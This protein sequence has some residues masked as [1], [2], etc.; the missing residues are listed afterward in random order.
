MKRLLSL[1]FSAALSSFGSAQASDCD[2]V[3][4][5]QIS[6]VESDSKYDLNWLN[7][8]NQSSYDTAKSSAG[9]SYYGDLF[10]A[11]YNSFKIN[12]SSLFK[13]KNF[14]SSESASLETFKQSLSE[15]QISGWVK[16]KVQANEIAIRYKNVSPNSATIVITW[17]PADA[18]GKLDNLSLTVTGGKVLGLATGNS[19]DLLGE[20]TFIVSR[21]VPDGEVHG[22]FSGRATSIGQNYTADFY[23]PKPV[24]TG[25]CRSAP[26]HAGD[27]AG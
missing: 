17:K 11:D 23:I 18:L 14:N 12:R 8:I 25:R 3:L 1:I 24:R 21:D 5:P 27:F 15:A 13:Q 10:K 2:A 4:I 26:C 7:I 9:A 19:S 6:T 20:Q 16:C 22:I